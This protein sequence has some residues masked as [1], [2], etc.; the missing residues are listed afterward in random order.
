MCKKTLLC[1][2]TSL[3]HVIHKCQIIKVSCIRSSFN[4]IF[5]QVYIIII[6]RLWLPNELIVLSR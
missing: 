1:G 2:I 4:L 6:P 3:V 5:F